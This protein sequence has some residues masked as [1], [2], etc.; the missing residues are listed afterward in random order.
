VE[1]QVTKQNIRVASLNATIG[2]DALYVPEVKFPKEFVQAMAGATTEK[3]LSC[4]TKTI[5]I[6]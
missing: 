5:K 2:N 4:N 3:A 6:K 1:F